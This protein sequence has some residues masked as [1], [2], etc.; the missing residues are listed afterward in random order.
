M[1]LAE[2]PKKYSNAGILQTVLLKF[3]G[4]LL[5]RLLPITIEVI[6]L[7]SDYDAIT[8]SPADILQDT[9]SQWQERCC[10][11]ERRL[12]NRESNRVLYSAE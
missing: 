10:L 9:L 7:D 12:V 1:E 8:W 5:Q 6:S 4:R 11:T 3:R 2:R